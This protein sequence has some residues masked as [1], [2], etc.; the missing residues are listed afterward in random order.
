MAKASPIV[1]FGDAMRAKRAAQTEAIVVER[2]ATREREAA[3][4]RA[5]ED[6]E[7]SARAAKLRRVAQ[8]EA[9]AGAIQNRL[10]ADWITAPMT[11]A[12]QDIR[13]GF[14]G[15]KDR[16]RELERNNGTAKRYCGLVAENV[17][18]HQGIRLQARVLDAAG[19]LDAGLNGYLAQE[20]LDWSEAETCS[21]DGR[22]SL[23]DFQLEA[24]RTLPK[25]GEVLLREVRGFPNRWGYALQWLDS[26][27]L[28]D[29]LNRPAVGG[30]NAIRMGVEEDAWGRPVRHHVWSGHPSDT[31]RR[32]R[33]PLASEDVIHL[34][35]PLRRGAPRGIT[36]FH[37][38]MLELRQLNGYQEAEL[39]AARIGACQMGFFKR[40]KESTPED[41][42]A[43]DSE[44]AP[45]VME[46]EAGLF[47]ELADGLE[48]QPWNPNHPVQA[49]GSFVK[50]SQRS[51]ATGLG[52]SYVSLFND[53]E[54]VS[55]SSIRQGVLA[56]R[57]CW[58]ILQSYASRHMMRRIYRSWL[59]MALVAGALPR[60]R[61]GDYVRLTRSAWL[62]R[63]WQW[64]DP[65]NDIQTAEKAIA[66]GLDSRTRINGE[67]GVDYELVLADLEH[68]AQLAAE[69]GVDVSVERKPASAPAPAA[70]EPP[71]DS[72]ADDAPDESGGASNPASPSNDGSVKKT[73]R[74]DALLR[75]VA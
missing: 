31:G 53:L 43:D 17:V 35:V 12:E 62:A 64:V 3:A 36:W 19:S 56:E 58:R 6:A 54:G 16:A 15:L 26:D 59:K 41:P 70:T 68:E 11:S 67:R 39:T 50:V 44:R 24:L 20:F 9:F 75:A 63:G 55:Y 2:R 51:I 57:D 8:R 42:N 65:L 40:T 73:K 1:G 28:D 18:G 74:G 5:R 72:S 69:Y 32:E 38:V 22:S 14:R 25:D 29:Q 48:L 61:A 10:T 45:L 37:P 71:S 21:V 27:Q 60:L 49:Y 52:V 4:A 23:V 30:Q 34:F 47:Q 33:L 46:A 7:A 66:L 13:A